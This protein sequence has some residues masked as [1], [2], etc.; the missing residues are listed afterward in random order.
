[1]KPFDIPRAPIDRRTAI[2]TF[3]KG[4]KQEGMSNLEMVRLYID[5][6]KKGKREEQPPR[7]ADG[8]AW[9]RPVHKTWVRKAQ[10]PGTP[11]L[12]KMV[13]RPIGLDKQQPTIENNEQFRHLSDF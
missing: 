2:V 10:S 8:K 3:G 4:V 11:L 6:G 9:P 5:L 13:I 12:T 7:R 1:M